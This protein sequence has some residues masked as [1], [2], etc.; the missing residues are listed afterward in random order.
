ME[1]VS[2]TLAQHLERV[3]ELVSRME[4]HEK[5]LPQI[6][7]D[8]LLAALREMYDA[9]YKLDVSE[10]AQQEEVVEEAAPVEMVA[11]EEVVDVV[12]A[13]E[14]A[15]EEPLEE[16]KEE[17]EMSIL[18]VDAD[19]EPIYAA[20]PD[21]LAQEEMQSQLPSVEDIEGQQNEELFEEEEN[22]QQNSVEQVV[23]EAEQ[24]ETVEQNVEETEPE[25]KEQ[26]KTIWEKLNDTQKKGTI[27]DAVA[28]T[29]TI[30]DVY[31]DANGKEEEKSVAPNAVQQNNQEPEKA[32]LK[33]ES[34]E[35]KVESEE[36]MPVGKTTVSQ[37]NGERKVE[38]KQPSLFDY[39]KPAAEKPAPKT[40]AESLGTGRVSDVDKKLNANKVSDLRT[41]INI[42]DKFSFMNELF[43]NNMK[44]YND[45]IM[46]LNAIEGREAAL[47]YVQE[48][49]QQYKWEEESLTVKTF[50]SV[51]D[52]KF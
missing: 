23:E 24:E 15:T 50:Y 6:E 22:V 3:R 19:A 42:N 39:F 29:R 13:E 27:A 47:A 18:M 36:K 26:P 12:E 4:M 2:K 37:D 33:S 28:A 8:M 14:K 49:A 16:K 1:K 44:G 40:L 32:E 41:V 17:P 5:S 43:H 10:E 11:E 20:D 45:F 35:Q 48:V 38:A 46:K 25:K 52:R 9:V 7:R 51:F 30:S 34:V 21:L 31:E